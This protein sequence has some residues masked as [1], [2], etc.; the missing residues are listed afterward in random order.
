V[1]IDEHAEARSA[2][3]REDAGAPP[4]GAAV[5]DAAGDTQRSFAGVRS[6]GQ[7]MPAEPARTQPPRPAPRARPW[8]I[9]LSAG[10]EAPGVGSHDAATQPGAA[11]E[12]MDPVLR[13]TRGPGSRVDGHA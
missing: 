4:V 2:P 7:A 5:A 1:L 10:G 13:V 8:D 9:P 3:A 12:G 6:E 11:S